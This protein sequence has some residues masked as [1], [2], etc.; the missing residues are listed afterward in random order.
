MAHKNWIVIG[1]SGVTCGGKSTLATALHKLYPSSVILNQ[2]D[3]F[4]PVDS[5]KHVLIPELNHF[6]WDILTAFD[7]HKMKSDITTTLNR[8]SEIEP[9]ILIIEGLLILCDEDVSRLCDKKYF[10]T[11][12]Y[13]IC[14]ER[15][16]KR[17]Y[18]PPDVPGYFDKC[19]WPEY[20]KSKEVALKLNPDVKVI[21]S[22]CDIETIIKDVNG[23][24]KK[25]L[26][27]FKHNCIH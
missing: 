7:M 26:G 5:D 20:L 25:L 17:T 22:L 9:N 14:L 3:Y 6:N 21:D 11:L 8:R 10:L 27:S 2:D 24:I 1:I 23:D 19:V 13:E 15:R 16:L 18:D 12:T 4:L